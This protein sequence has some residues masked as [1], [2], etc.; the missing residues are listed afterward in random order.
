[1]FWKVIDGILMSTYGVGTLVTILNN[2]SSNNRIRRKGYEIKP[3]DVNSI[4]EN[5]KYFIKDFG[6]LF[7]P[8]YNLIHSIKQT[9]QN[10]NEFDNNK[11]SKLLD[12]DRLEKF[13][14][15]EVVK[16]VKKVVEQKNEKTNNVENTE[17]PKLNEKRSKSFDELNCYE[18][19]DF[20]KNE[21]NRVL[22]LR[23]NAKNDGA[24]VAILNRYTAELESIV[25]NYKKA[26]RECK[27]NNLKEAKDSLNKSD[28]SEK[29]L[30]RK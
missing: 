18:R 1:M 5:I 17:S 23:T 2:S 9:I 13:S 29:K 15:K 28:S 26:Q 3:V 19:C 12:R 22:S 16:E 4:S 20:Y 21:Y 14:E 25:E 27:I 8:V 6:F 11:M 10:D 30:I 24:S 7:I